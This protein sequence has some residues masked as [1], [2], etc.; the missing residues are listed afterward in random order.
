MKNKVLIIFGIIVF[1]IVS[2]CIGIVISFKFIEDEIELIDSDNTEQLDNINKENDDTEKYTNIVLSSKIGNKVLS[3]FCISNIYSN[4][5]Y[6]KLDSE[7]FTQDSKL[8][9][10]YAT[11]V[12]NYDYHNII[13]NSDEY[14]EYITK[15]DFENVYKSLFGKDSSITNKSI[16]TEDLYNEENEYYNYL[17]FGYGGVKFDFIVEIPYKI[18]EYEDRI[19]ATFYRVYATSDSTIKEDGTQ[20]QV[21]QLFENSTRTTAVYTSEDVKLQS[22]DSQQEFIK[23]LIENETLNKE[24]LSIITYTLKEEND[25]Y[26]I[27]DVKNVQAK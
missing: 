17:T 21:V 25:E 7:G 3:K 9:Y 12:S 6:D 15:N 1:I 19:E 23:E 22:N 20:N 2:I 4:I 14:G 10:T 27:Q 8:I 16:I 5:V 18:K 24:N 13:R 11:I 26:Y